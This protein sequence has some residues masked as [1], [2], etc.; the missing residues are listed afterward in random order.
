MRRPLLASLLAASLLAAASPSSFAQVLPTDFTD[1]QIVPGLN[2]PVGFDFLPDGRLLLVEQ[3]SARVRMV[4]AGALS[5]VDPV[6]TVPDVRSG[7]ERGLLGIAVDPRW[8]AQPYIYVHSTSTTGFVRIS[9]FL[10]GGDLD[11]SAGSG[12]S[13]NPTSRYDL[14]DDIPDAQF[15]H[16]GGT[17]RFGPDSLLYVS[18]G[19][20]A[21]PCAAQDTVSL[22]G[23]LLRLEVR[24][25]PAGPGSASRA[26]ITP[27]DNPY[28]SHPDPDARLVA[29]T[30]LR[31]PFRVQVDPVRNWLL[32]GDVGQVTHEE[33]DVVR[34]PGATGTLGGT[35]GADYGWP[36]FEGPAAFTTCSGSNAGR[37]GPSYSYDRT[38][39]PGGASIIVAGAYRP[40][41]GSADWPAEYHGDVFISDYYSGVLRRLRVSGNQFALA[42]TVPG[43]PDATA[44]GTGFGAVS[45]YRMGPD[46]S[47]WYLRQAVSFQSNSGSLR[48]VVYA[49]EAPPPPPSNTF[50]LALSV[51]P[52]PAVGQATI[53]FTPSAAARVTAR[54]HDL[55]G[56]VV[57]TLLSASDR[58]AARY[59][60]TWDGSDD[61]G[62]SV[63]AGLYIVRIEAAGLDRS[64]RVML[65]R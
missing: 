53:S 54:I 25:L 19:E 33:L 44:W 36:W 59:D 49:G 12:L 16:N 57:R 45:D 1:E 48:R 62:Q 3:A 46:G 37:T 10:V 47:L 61:V 35:L 17:L 65:I 55:S 41:G 56:R 24:G 39:S 26:L 15:N 51:A 9:R 22:R 34:L 60:L 4:Q 28:V 43:Q 27:A 14:I 63:P 5:T 40:Q 20:D 8:P 21:S 13:A 52:Q 11:G 7:S 38:G 18:L 50:S 32:V 31:N 30:G 64:Q 29:V 23:V 2:F 58:A 6:L 42:P